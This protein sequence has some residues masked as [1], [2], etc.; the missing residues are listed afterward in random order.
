MQHNRLKRLSLKFPGNELKQQQ[1]HTVGNIQKS[2]RTKQEV[3]II[4]YQ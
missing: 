2:K 1:R 3:N 4:K